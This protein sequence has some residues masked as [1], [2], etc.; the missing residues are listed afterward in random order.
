MEFFA[1]AE[2]VL[3]DIKLSPGQLALLRA[4]DRA[5]QQRLY[6]LEEGMG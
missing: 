3:G 2:K 6:T 1:V 5:Y 4:I